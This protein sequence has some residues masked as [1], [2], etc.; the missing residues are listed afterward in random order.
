MSTFGSEAKVH[1][2]CIPDLLDLICELLEMNDWLNL[3][4]T[5]RSIF[6]VIAS[7]IWS[8]VEA[9]V[10]LDLIDEAPVQRSN[11]PAC[12][13]PMVNSTVDFARFNIYAPFVRRLR[14]YGRTARY[15]K[16]ERRRIC[17]QWARQGTLLPNVTSVTLLTSDLYPDSESLFWFDLFLIPSLQELSVQPVARNHTAWVSYEAT[18]S[19]LGKLITTCSAIERL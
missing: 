13:N 17:T 3:M 8:E 12:S 2:L 6:P 1:G 4:K 16:G 15:F 11:K 7:R 10:I 5:C 14:V 9:Q 18:T 19:I